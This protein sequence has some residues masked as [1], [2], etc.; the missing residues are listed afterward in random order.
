M[1]AYLTLL[2]DNEITAEII[3]QM[4]EDHKPERERMEHLYKRYRGDED[5]VPIFK[6]MPVKHEDFEFGNAKRLDDKIN[7]M[8]Y[9]GFEADIVDTK[10]GYMFGNEIQ[11]Q[12]E[13]NDTFEDTVTRFNRINNM[14]DMDS[15]WGK[16]AA[17]CGMGA[18]LAFINTDGN[19]DVRNVDPWECF[20]IGEDDITEPTYAGRVFTRYAW[21]NTTKIKKRVVHFYTDTYRY[22]FEGREQE[23]VQFVERKRH[24]FEYCPLWGLPNNAEHMAD[25]ERVL[26]LIDAYNRTL[27]DASNEIEQYRLAYLILK[28]MGADD[29]TLN[30]MRDSG[31]LELFESGDDASY[32]TKDI[33]DQLIEHHL[34][35]LEANIM[36]MAKSVNFTDEQFGGNVTG[37]AMRYKIMALENKSKAMER[38]MHTAL[39]YQYKVLCSAWATKGNANRDDYESLTFVFTRNLPVN[40][41]EEAE[42]MN[43]LGIRVSQ[44]TGLQLFSAVDD[45]EEEQERVSEDDDEY[46][47]A[48]R[49]TSID[50]NDNPPDKNT[51][52]PPR[53]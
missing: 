14:A 32:L 17:A 44:R 43:L 16:K 52:P 47:R 6:R 5:A 27:S 8:L 41:K 29:E 35:R 9:N 24:L 19:P 38:K 12:V 1:N 33:N 7:N 40:T 22:T 37:I 36:R 15:E 34:D 49:A 13:D 46:M 48:A 21:E 10:Q 39:R 45:P 18:R 3:E 23:K 53:E 42:I 4:L 51:D 20:F 11:Y 25:A 2:Q 31:V 28:G 26:E 50:P 30:K